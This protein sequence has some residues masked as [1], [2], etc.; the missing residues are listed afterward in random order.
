MAAP[1]ALGSL[2]AIEGLTK[3]AG[4]AAAAEARAEVARAQLND[5]EPPPSGEVVPLEDAERHLPH[6]VP[7]R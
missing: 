6:V 1:F 4:A 2:A 7:A 3:S 5:L